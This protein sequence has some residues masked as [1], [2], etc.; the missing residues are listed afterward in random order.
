MT[1]PTKLKVKWEPGSYYVEIDLT[2]SE[3]HVNRQLKELGEILGWSDGKAEPDA[4]P[5]MIGERG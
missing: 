2:K 4:T 5:P 3:D 1:R